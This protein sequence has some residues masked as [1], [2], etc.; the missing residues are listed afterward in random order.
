MAGLRSEINEICMLASRVLPGIDSRAYMPSHRSSA[1]CVSLSECPTTRQTRNK[2]PLIFCGKKMQVEFRWIWNPALDL[3]LD[4]LLPLVYSLAFAF[5]HFILVRFVFA[6]VA[7]RLV[8]PEYTRSKNSTALDNNNNNNNATKSNLR[9]RYKNQR[10]KAS[11]QAED[12]DANLL[13]REKV[14]RYSR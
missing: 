8:P 7:I 13:K 5:A 10:K 11:E 4:L 6:P 9:K 3:P 1:A 14:Y 12:V 2:I